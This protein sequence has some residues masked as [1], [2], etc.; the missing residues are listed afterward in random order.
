MMR[1]TRPVVRQRF[2]ARGFSV[3][4]MMIAI[5]V[6]S[7]LMGAMMGFIGRMQEAYTAEQ[8]LS[9]VNQGGKTAMDLLAID[10]AQAGFPPVVTRTTTAAI[11][12]SISSQSVGVDNSTG[13][14]VGRPITIDYGVN[15]ETVT[16]TAAG[17]NSITGVFKL[18]H[19]SG[20][21]IRVSAMPYPSGIIFA[22]TGTPTSTGT[23]LELVGDIR[24]DGTLRYI[25]YDYT[26]P[27]GTTAGFLTRSD[28]D[29]FASTRNAAV[30]V[31][32]NL[33]DASAIFTY[34]IAL[35]TCTGYTNPSYVTVCTSSAAAGSQP[36][37]LNVGVTLT[38]RTAAAI[39]RGAGA[40]GAREVVIRQQYF[41]P[42]NILNAYNLSSDGLFTLL[43]TAPGAVT[44]SLAQ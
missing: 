30:T 4:E 24:G 22:K 23:R 42:R 27:V 21:V 39:E 26:A 14:Y 8:K 34:T 3:V 17:S 41:T 7:V 20:S 36:F 29:A 31:L 10:I 13:L 40:G 18:S 25:Q 38:M 1:S 35:A 6:L 11:T 28:T 12:G 43:P 9:G 2:P 32:D 33:W 44:T 19:V 5:A 16:L 37:V 15:E